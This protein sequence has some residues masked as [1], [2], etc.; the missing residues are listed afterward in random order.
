MAAFDPQAR[1]AVLEREL[2]WAHLKIQAL[3]E[4]LRQQRVKLLG[5]RSET[6]SNLQLE[7]LADDEPG[8]TLDEVEAEPRRAP[9][10]EVP[11]RQRRPHPGRQR[12]PENLPRVEEIVACAE[13]SCAQCGADPNRL[14][15]KVWSAGSTT[16]KCNSRSKSDR[17]AGRNP[18][19]HLSAGRIVGFM[20]QSSRHRRSD[21]G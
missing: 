18:I 14:M 2:A 5:P 20:R 8:T 11:P 4:E 7:L 13:Q 15:V 9:L 17:K 10:A 21:H 12:L 19:A 1:I 6:L 16:D 3:T